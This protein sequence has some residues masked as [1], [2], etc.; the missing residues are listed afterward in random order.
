[1]KPPANYYD[2]AAY[3]ELTPDQQAQLQTWIALLFAPIGFRAPRVRYCSYDLKHWFE[4]CYDRRIP[5]TNRLE[6]LPHTGTGFYVTDGQ[7]KGA[8]LAAGRVPLDAAAQS[9]AFD[10]ALYHPGLEVPRYIYGLVDPRTDAVRYVGQT[11]DLRTRLSQHR[12][13]LGWGGP[14][15]QWVTD[16]YN[17]GT[18]RPQIVTLDTLT[19]AP[20]DLLSRFD[21][22]QAFMAAVNFAERNWIAYYA[23]EGA[24]LLNVVWAGR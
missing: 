14:F 10:I 11:N 2:P 20:G 12:L 21:R 4:R 1:M 17:A 24:A 5:G 8:M 3:G 18:L 16:L 22:L 6:R 19:L 9:W 13:S 23:G 15:T 7:F